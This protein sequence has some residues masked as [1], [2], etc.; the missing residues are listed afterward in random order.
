MEHGSDGL[1]KLALSVEYWP[2]PAVYRS[3][4]TAKLCGFVFFASD[5][6]EA[7]NQ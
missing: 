7:K 3:E 6:G 5:G 1:G 4:D 2:A